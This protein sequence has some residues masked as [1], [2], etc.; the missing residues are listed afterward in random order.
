MHSEV[1]STQWLITSE[2]ANQRALKVLFICV[3][4]TK[5]KCTTRGGNRKYAKHIRRFHNIDPPIPTHYLREMP[6]VILTENA[7]EFN[8]KKL[9]THGVAMGTKTA[10]SF[11]KYIHGGD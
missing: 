11:C 2:L 10:V 4:Y 5:H 9:Q 7:F 3:V 8:E 1:S 6:G